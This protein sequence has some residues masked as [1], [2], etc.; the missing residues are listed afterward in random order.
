[1][2]QHPVGQR[3]QPPG[4]VGGGELRGALRWAGGVDPGQVARLE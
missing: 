1:M 4:E 3:W 2:A